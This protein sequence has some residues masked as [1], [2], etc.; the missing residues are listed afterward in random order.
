MITI[1]TGSTI[2]IVHPSVLS[3]EKLERFHP[4]SG[5]LHTVTR[6]KVPFRGKS[7]LTLQIGSTVNTQQVW[8]ADI[9]DETTQ[10]PG[11]LGRVHFP[12]S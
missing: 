11:E 10:L 5:W 6:E 8:V 1:D 7:E 3:K 4:V 12:D 2:T 9:Q